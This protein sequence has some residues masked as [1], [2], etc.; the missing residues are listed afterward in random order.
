MRL[1]RLA[2]FVAL[3]NVV[4]AS[5]VS[6]TTAH[7]AEPQQVTVHKTETVH[8]T[9][10]PEIVHKTETVHVTQPPETVHEV[11]TVHVTQP[12]ET[13]HKTET[14]HVTQPPE[15]VHEVETVHV[16]QPPETVHEVETV[17]VT[18]P[19]ETV[20]EVETVHVTEEPQTVHVTETIHATETIHVTAPPQVEHVTAT[21][22]KTKVKNVV[23][24]KVQEK[25]V[26]TTVEKPVTVVETSVVEKPVTVVETVH[27]PV[28]KHVTVTAENPH[29]V[30]ETV[31][32]TLCPS[33]PSLVHAYGTRASEISTSPGT[34]P[35]G[36]KDHGPF[37]RFVGLD[38]TSI[39]AAA[40]SGP[41]AVAI[42][43]L[44]CML[45]RV[46]TPAEAVSIWE[47][48]VAERKKTLVH[49]EELTVTKEQ[50]AEW[51]ANA[52]AWLRAADGSRAV[53]SHQKNLVK[54][55]NQL[56]LPVGSQSMVYEN[57]CK[58]W[59]TALMTVDK[60]VQGH[61][62]S[63]QDGAVLLAL[64]SWHLYPDLIVLGSSTQELRLGDDLIAPG[65][66]LTIGL[67]SS[68]SDAFKGVHWSLSLAHLRYYGAPVLAS[69]QNGRHIQQDDLFPV[70]VGGAGCSDGL[71]GLV[72]QPDP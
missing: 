52:R 53:A 64:S 60:L 66:A 4:N 34:S 46:W 11:E 9:L 72:D 18:L 17:H 32:V 6:V 54:L 3:G 30:T 37:Q 26:T 36:S 2:F 41:S 67:Q 40:T 69:G 19:P 50:L 49:V 1:Q 45:A 59:V 61:P 29:P 23:E 51:D 58:T 13:V 10:P 25:L 42:H 31:H 55:L 62:Y 33:T 43:L 38:G 15:T 21:E 56:S 57:V 47:E 44:A 48:L 35:P 28:V 14:V 8:V 24:T 68:D 65:G 12:A 22:T 5:P 39:W 20:H 27:E 71:L 16:T 70:P 7:P 63:A